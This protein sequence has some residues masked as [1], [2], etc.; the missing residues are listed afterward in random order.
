MLL[1]TS[2]IHDIRLFIVSWFGCP[3]GQRVELQRGELTGVAEYQAKPNYQR[4]E[5]TGEAELS[6]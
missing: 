5:L 2:N 4:S 1:Q 6:A 3:A